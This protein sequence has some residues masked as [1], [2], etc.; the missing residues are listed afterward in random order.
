M[1]EDLPTLLARLVDPLADRLEL[2]LERVDPVVAD[3]LDVEDLDPPLAFL[4]PKRALAPG[5]L[6]GHKVRIV[7]RH[8]ARARRPDMSDIQMRGRDERALAHRN[9]VRDPKCMQHE[10]VGGMVPVEPR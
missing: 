2:R 5:S 4:D 3:A 1:H 8:R 6:P 10:R 9:D 7:V